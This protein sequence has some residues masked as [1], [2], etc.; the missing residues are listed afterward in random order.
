MSLDFMNYGYLLSGGVA[1]CFLQVSARVNCSL[2]AG[3]MGVFSV[4]LFNCFEVLCYLS[5]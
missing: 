2:Q 4:F 3:L 5:W 1:F